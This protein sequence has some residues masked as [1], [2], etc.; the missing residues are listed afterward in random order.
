MYKLYLDANQKISAVLRIAD[1]AIIPMDIMNT[2]YQ[3]YLQWASE[4][5]APEPADEPQQ[6]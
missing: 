6:A 1:N 2:D 4:G 5:N 3:E